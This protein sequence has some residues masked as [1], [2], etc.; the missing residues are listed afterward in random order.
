[1]WMNLF[2][3]AAAHGKRDGELGYPKEE[4][5]CLYEI[6]DHIDTSRVKLLSTSNEPADDSSDVKARNVKLS[7]Y[8]I[9]QIS[10][11]EKAISKLHE[12]WEARRHKIESNIIKL[13]YE[14]KQ[15]INEYKSVLEQFDAL[16]KRRPHRLI[17]PIIYFFLMLLLGIFEFPYN[18]SVFKE[19][20]PA[21][22]LHFGMNLEAVFVALGVSMS[23]LILAHF[24]GIK[25]RQWSSD[26]KFKSYLFSLAIIVAAVVVLDS[27][28]VLRGGYVALSEQAAMANIVSLDAVSTDALAI[29]PELGAEELGGS[30]G[31]DLALYMM[32]INVGFFVVGAGVSNHSHDENREVE[33][34]DSELN[35]LENKI[36]KLLSKRVS[37]VSTHDQLLKVSQRRISRLKQQGLANIAEYRDWNMRY[38]KPDSGKGF[39][40]NVPIGM[41]LFRTYDLGSELDALTRSAI[42]EELGSV[43]LNQVA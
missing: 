21:D 16:G 18:Y 19:I 32:L 13:E 5:L 27:L 28:Y 39:D 42:E 6:Q 22:Q 4:D 35:K 20:F 8:E 15:T 10:L 23:L 37:L 12:G 31:A 24:V 11:T 3:T 33:R 36:H 41:S 25:L 34:V 2:N 1:M 9:E 7:S 29:T 14:A 40:M 38:R 17:S 26:W 30:D 43:A